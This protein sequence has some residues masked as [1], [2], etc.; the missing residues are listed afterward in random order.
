MAAD[1]QVLDDTALRLLYAEH[2]GPLL[3]Y[4][5]R[6]TR[7]HARAEDLLQETMLRAWRRPAVFE[8]ERGAVRGWLR[9]VAR[10]LVVDDIRAR[11]ARP[12]ERELVEDGPHA[13]DGDDPYDAA[14]LSWEV[15][16]ALSALSPQHRAVLIEV[17]YRRASVG[18]AAKTLGIAPG[19]VKS[20][21]FYALRALRAGCPTGPC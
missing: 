15:A 17:Y 21:T 1:T 2:A 18:E 16:D 13:G 10:N 19:T 14:I 4:L 6:L 20:R 9:T 8:P 12:H 7:D 11:A 5:L 3:A